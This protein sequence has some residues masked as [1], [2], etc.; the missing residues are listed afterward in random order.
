MPDR[1]GVGFEIS[2][3]S[4]LEGKYAMTSRLFS[5]GG[6]GVLA[7]I[8]GLSVSV[9]SAQVDR[10]SQR[11]IN[12]TCANGIYCGSGRNMPRPGG[13]AVR[14]HFD[15]EVWRGRNDYRP[16]NE[17]R[18]PRPIY[19]DYHD[20]R[21]YRPRYYDYDRDTDV[22]LDFYVPSYR[23][24][25]PVPVY[26]R[27]AYRRIVMSQAHVEWCYNRYRTYRERDNTY[28]PRRGKRA[29]CISPYS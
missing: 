9:A 11:S 7:A 12:P 21:P 2:Q 4:C 5:W 24:Y 22:Y 16:R 23:T 1:L 13:D 20:Y 19:R 29:Q 27:R 6:L 28:V 17:Y 26:P 15:R 10:R 18:P 14:Q 25:D 8:L 3:G